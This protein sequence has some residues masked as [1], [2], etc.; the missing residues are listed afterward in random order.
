MHPHD[1]IALLYGP[2]RAP[3]LRKGDRSTCLYR[4]C[5]VV[6]TSWTDAPIP[7]PRCRA[8]EHRRGA[9]GLLVDD[10]LL[11]AIR[12]ESAVAVMHWW[13]VT[14]SVVWCWRRA[15]LVNKTNNEGSNRLVRAAAEKGGA[16]TQGREFTQVERDAQRQRAIDNDLQRHLRGLVR[17]DTWT[18]EEIALLGQLP[19]AVVARKIRRTVEAVRLKRGKLS[20]ANPTTTHWTAEGIAL[21]GV[22]PDTEVAKCLGRS[23]GSVA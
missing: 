5:D 15:F 13:Q 6:I 20:L 11:R 17:E 10:E 18:E 23:A 2:Y 8:V 4:D 16:A 3:A 19:D 21:P 22:M 12:H 14:A 1:R 7:W 9:P